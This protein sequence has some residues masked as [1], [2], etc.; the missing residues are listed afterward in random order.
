MRI[1]TYQL[2]KINLFS[3]HLWLKRR[4]KK[5]NIIAVNIKYQF[6]CQAQ[7]KRNQLVIKTICLFLGPFQ[8]SKIEI[9][10]SFGKSI[11]DI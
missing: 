5:L 7:Y 4:H 6:S 3:K 11:V 8:L 2:N 10:K 1:T 9:F